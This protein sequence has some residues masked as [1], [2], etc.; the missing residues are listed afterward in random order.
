MKAAFVIHKVD[1]SLYA[2]TTWID[3]SIRFP[4]GPILNGETPEESVVR[5]SKE[6]GWG[7]EGL[8]PIYETSS[9][10]WFSANKCSI[11][12]NHKGNGLVQ[13]CTANAEKLRSGGHTAALTSYNTECKCFNVVENFEFS[14][15]LG[16]LTIPPDWTR[17]VRAGGVSF[18]DEEEFVLNV[19]P[20]YEHSLDTVRK[21]A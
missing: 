20:T 16:H 7:V 3:N 13:L 1:H 5:T 15:L 11:L 14:C 21:Y 10:I 17:C 8:K 9:A 19:W 4:G 6:E 18:Y 12:P 2:A